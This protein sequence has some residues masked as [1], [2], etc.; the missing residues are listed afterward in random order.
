MLQDAAQP[1]SEKSLKNKRKEDF[2][3]RMGNAQVLTL[4]LTERDKTRTLATEGRR[5]T[6]GA[7]GR[8][9]APRAGLL[10]KC[11]TQQNGPR[12]LYCNQAWSCQCSRGSAIPWL[13]T[14]TTPCQIRLRCS[15]QSPPVLHQPPHGFP[16]L[17]FIPHAPE[18]STAL[19]RIAQKLLGS[20]F[21]SL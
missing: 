10:L 1:E 20:P 16:P 12:A 3:A 17:L 14:P 2:Q 8:L 7:A 9:H 5:R 21:L 6:H 19:R 18:L 13:P 15:A 4:K 11:P